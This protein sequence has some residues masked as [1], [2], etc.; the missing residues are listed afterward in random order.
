MTATEF[1]HD[2]SPLRP[3]RFQF[4]LRTL[5]LLF[6]VLG[7]SM[8][9]FG[10]WGILVFALVLGAAFDLNNS[11]PYY[12]RLVFRLV[13]LIVFCAV[14]MNAI[15]A[16]SRAGHRASC[17]NR[18][19]QLVLALQ[20]YYATNSRLPPACSV[21][22]NGKPLHSWRVLILP[23]LEY[24]YIYKSLNLALPWNAPTNNNVLALQMRE[25]SCP[26]DPTSQAR[27]TLQTNYFAVVGPNTAW[28]RSKQVPTSGK[29]AA[30]TIMLVEVA[31]SGVAWAEPRD[32]SLEK[33]G[34][35]GWSSPALIPSSHHGGHDEDFFFLYDSEQRFIAAM[36]DGSVQVIHVNGL[37]PAQLRQL[38]EIGGC[39]EEV[40]AFAKDVPTVIRPNWPNIAALAVWLVSVG[41]LLVVALRSRKRPTSESANAAGS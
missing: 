7:S 31:D 37:S 16:A 41:T 6:V 4:S 20:N 25:F 14:G 12:V 10:V 15:D 26:S 36:A 30:N 5:L 27:G 29:E 32:V 11:W 34:A 24:K 13:V 1:P 39:T 23:F 35:D 17:L 40:L 8:S 18:M 28:D 33:L 19:H 38:F 2:A 9:V 3:P 22:K 21:D